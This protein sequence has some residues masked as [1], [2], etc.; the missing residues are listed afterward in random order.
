MYFIHYFTLIPQF[1]LE[2]TLEKDEYN[3]PELRL[4]YYG[5]E[6]HWRRYGLD[7]KDRLESVGFNVDEIVADDLVKT[8]EEKE[9]YNLKF[10]ND[11][12]YICTK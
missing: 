1:N 3:T 6:D 12:L 8:K 5:Q 9:L 10:G 11:I 7:F 2:T 4:K